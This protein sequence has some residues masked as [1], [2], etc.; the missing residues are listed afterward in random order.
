MKI[1]ATRNYK[2]PAY[3]IG[4]LYIDGALCCNTLE[5]RVRE[6]A[7]DGSGKIRGITAIP[8]GEYKVVVTYSPKFRRK[9]PLLVGVPHFDGIRIHAGNTA[10]DTEGC[11]LVGR[12]T[13]RGRLTES[14]RYE[15][16]ITDSII[17]A[18]DRGE[19]VTINISD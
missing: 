5:D 17:A 7:A 2:K 16:E 18:I 1:L 4:M 15:K 3:T 13:A 14:R 8:A 19:E 6:I 9:L 10:D 11:I 12:N